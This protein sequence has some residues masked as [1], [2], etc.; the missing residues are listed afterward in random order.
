VYGA[1]AA[2]A[3]ATLA[4]WAGPEGLA[5]PEEVDEVEELEEELEL[6]AAIDMTAATD[7]QAAAAIRAERQ[8]A[9][10]PGPRVLGPGRAGG[11]V[12]AG[13]S[14]LSRASLPP[15]RSLIFASIFTLHACAK[16]RCDAESGHLLPGSLAPSARP[17]APALRLNEPNQ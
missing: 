8:F 7:T 14:D 4:P 9:R 17:G 10:P 1:S 12:G 2:A 16:E 15:H 11:P 13:S 3:A 5:E 6:Q